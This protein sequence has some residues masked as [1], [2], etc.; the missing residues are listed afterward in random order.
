MRPTPAT[1]TLHPQRLGPVA[2]P[3]LALA[4]LTGRWRAALCRY[5]LESAQEVPPSASSTAQT[6][7]VIRKQRREVQPGGAPRLTALRLYYVLNGVCYEAPCL[8]AV[9]RARLVRLGWLLGRAFE[10]L[11]SAVVAPQDEAVPPSRATSR[12]SQR[13]ASPVSRKRAR[14]GEPL[15][16]LDERDA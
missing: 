3:G 4:L 9:L 8:S 5:L 14:E 1:H 15:L 11:H 10:T 12:A 7:Y 6:L 2:P 13:S 16:E